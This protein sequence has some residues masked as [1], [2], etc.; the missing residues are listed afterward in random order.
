[1]A[2]RP[3]GPAL[4]AA[5]ARFGRAVGL[6]Y[7]GTAA[8]AMLLLVSALLTDLQHE[9]QA[10]R[11]TLSLET[12]VRA[13]YLS[14]HLQ[15]LADELTRLGLRSEVDLLDENMAPEMSLLRLSH[16]KSTFFNVGVAV[17]DAGGSVLWAEPQSFFASG[18]L[19][20]SGR[21][22]R[23]LKQTHTRQIIPAP[24][25]AG[26]PSGIVYVVSP[27]LRNGV[28]T[29]ALLGAVDLV[30][31]G[32]LSPRAAR[33]APAAVALVG[34]EGP[35]LASPPAPVVPAWAIPPGTGEPAPGPQ[36]VEEQ[37]TVTAVAPVDGTPFALLSQA[38]AEALFRSARRRF[39]MRLGLG[40]GLSL[41]PLVGLSFL[42]HRSL[43]AFRQSEED[44][45]RDERL[46]SLGEAADVIAHE[47]KNSL[48][49]LRVA[50]D[51]VLS[52]ERVALDARHRQ[53]VAGM[54]TEIQH[55]SSFTT[56]LLSFSKGFVPRPALLDL[57]GFVGKVA[58]LTFSGAGPS[59][60][61]LRVVPPP[62]PIRI[63]A[64][65]TLV[66]VVIANLVRNAL[67]VTDLGRVEEPGLIVVETTVG[68]GTQARVRVTDNGPG[69]PETIKTRLFEPF[70]TAKPS[71]VGLGL[72]LSRSIARAHGGDLVLIDSPR[73]AA[74]ELTLPLE[75]KP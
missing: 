54:R 67:D 57:G 11:D 74:F 14:S 63:H 9:K 16:E 71:G 24:R 5:H 34:P 43:R 66:H 58:Q 73:G 18:V 41:V 50:L 17:L 3:P 46:R 38:D 37:G 13:Y 48:N 33:G 12:Q 39:T 23:A 32:R 2:T 10:S 36:V 25:D 52:D 20:E 59:H 51:L 30:K 75:R 62:A 70:V 60:A 6:V 72:S 4:Q 68:D 27:I 64:D 35:V 44:A 29:G 21:L 8:L 15:L 56:D 65:P 42:L 1:V 69:V 55:L 45:V 22:L 28:F 19:P 53:A 31:S 40:L 61:E 47:V 26:G 7:G 49:G